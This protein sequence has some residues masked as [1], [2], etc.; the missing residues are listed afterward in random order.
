MYLKKFVRGL[1]SQKRLDLGEIRLKCFF[2]LR[3][4]GL[5]WTAQ[6]GHYSSKIRGGVVFCDISNLRIS[7]TIG[8]IKTN[9][10][11]LGRLQPHFWNL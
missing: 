1:G 11:L 5:P 9:M 3:I 10:D 4:E 8:D 6:S 7:K 2:Y